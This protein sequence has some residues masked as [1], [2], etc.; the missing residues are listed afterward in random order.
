[1]MGDAFYFVSNSS[2]AKLAF[3]T[4]PSL[5]DFWASLYMSSAF[6]ACAESRDGYANAPKTA[7]NIKTQT[8]LMIV[9]G[10]ILIILLRLG[11]RILL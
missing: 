7:I 2:R 1:M 5:T 8:P 10:F 3:P 9:C 11:V 6:T 4:L